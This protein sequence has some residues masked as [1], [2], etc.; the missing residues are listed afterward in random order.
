ME[1][2]TTSTT[3]LHTCRTLRRASLNR[4]FALAYACAITSLL[5]HH[6]IKLLHSPTLISFTISA[7]MLLADFLLA[8]MWATTQS[9]RICPI[10]R[11]Q[12]PQNLHKVL[13]HSNDFPP[14]DIFICTADPYKE[15]PMSVVNTALSVMAY[16]YPIEKVSV[17]VSD[18][19][20]SELTL[21]AFMEAAKFAAHWLAFCREN[22]V[23]ERCPE[24]FFRSNY[25]RSSETEEIKTMYESMK[26]RVENVVEKGKVSEEFIT[27]EDE[28]EVFNK[29]N[30][31]GLFTRQDHP[32]IIQVLLESG[33]DIDIG[34]RWMPNLIYLSRQK[35]RRSPHHFKAGALNALV[36]VSAVMSNAP[37]ILTLDCD[38][39]SNDPQTPHRALCYLHD[40][41]ETPTLGYIQFPQRYHGLNKADIYAS[42]L[43][44]LFITNPVGMDGLA[45]P[46][47]VGTGCFFR[48]RAF[49]GGPFSFVSP[50]IQELSPD[51]VVD[52]PIVA[53]PI[54]TLAHNVA[55][56]TYENETT[57]GSKMGFRYG[58]LVEDYYTGYRLQ[59]EGW[60]SVF[61]HPDRPAFLGDVPISLV[62]VL[63]QNKRWSIG[64][65]EVAFSKYSPLTFG[66]RAMGPVMGLC[67]AHYAFWPIWSV[68]I[69]IYSFIPQLALLN[70]VSIFPKVTDPMFIVYAFLFIGAHAQDCLDFILAQG[71]FIRWWSDQRMWLVR[72]V[73]SYLF[74]SLEFATKHLGIATHGF[75]I[76]SKVQD[77][78]QSKRYDQGTFEF[79]VAS[80]MFVSLAV[81][82]VLNFIAFISSF[83]QILLGGNV[84]GLFVQ[85]FIAGFGVLNCLPI[86]EAMALRSD[87]GRIPNKVTIISTFVAW[88]LYVVV[89][90]MLR[91]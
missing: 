58:S 3:T 60:K 90:F 10:H 53:Q 11:Q 42:E 78:E 83:L 15:P 24:A 35:C 27:N 71:T 28:R 85:I 12:F 91:M 82:A 84:E 1:T 38:M 88:V 34:G 75:N 57:W 62:D 86:Y 59:C 61:C 74:G 29:W 64:L 79:G 87:K 54:L 25:M 70:K 80:P 44:R 39:Y 14:I 65:L 17:Y 55:S 30:C 67:Y 46:S 7:S 6:S 77:D 36:R 13:K 49:F 66:V 52:N 72:G 41:S 89:S 33:K 45:G 20:G 4:V 68:P 21:F 31:Q 32:T 23:L 8:F 56:C 47:Y 22:M 76:T 51:H 2:P 63:G 19:G 50:E 81:A 9:F 48:R 40:P 73:S 43:K 37:I 5:Y 16:D 69:T 18:D 26:T